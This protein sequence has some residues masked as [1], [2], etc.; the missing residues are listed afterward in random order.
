MVDDPEQTDARGFFIQA[1]ELPYR[2][3]SDGAAE[4]LSDIASRNL[5]DEERAFFGSTPIPALSSRQGM[6]PYA[7]NVAGFLRKPEAFDVRALDKRQ[8]R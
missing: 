3:A 8:A 4:D 7:S 2:I 1:R 6:N 5:S